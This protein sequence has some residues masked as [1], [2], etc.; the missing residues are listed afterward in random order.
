MISLE[1]YKST[2]ANN[3]ANLSEIRRNNADML[4]NLTFTQDHEYK[5]VRVLTSD[6]WKWEDAKYIKHTTPSIL[7]DEVDY[8]LQFR[9]K[10]HFK[11]GTYV[12]VPDDTSPE[13][14]TP[15]DPFDQDYADRTQWWLIVGRT[16]AN[17]FVRYSILKMNWDFV[18]IY[19]GEIRHCF[20][21]VRNA[22]SYT[23]KIIAPYK[24]KPYRIIPW[25]AGNSLSF[26]NYN[27]RMKYA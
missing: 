24:R 6:G 12:I 15:E 2:L 23:S 4:T 3:G 13:V 9:P 26:I 27:I 19:D 11:L 14:N 16:D 8:Y 1:S 17:Q 10:T 22:N 18:W 7:K 5:R 21:C 25:N 20:G